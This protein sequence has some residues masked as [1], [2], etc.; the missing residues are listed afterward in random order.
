MRKLMDHILGAPRFIRIVQPR[1]DR[2][3]DYLE[4]VFT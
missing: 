4:R 3:T 2:L 1:L